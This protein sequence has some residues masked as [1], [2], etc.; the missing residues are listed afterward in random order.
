MPVEDREVT[1]EGRGQFL[2]ITFLFSQINN[3]NLKVI[4]NINKTAQG[5]PFALRPCIRYRMIP[6]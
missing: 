4:N 1:H 2:K 3:I 5:G 6:I